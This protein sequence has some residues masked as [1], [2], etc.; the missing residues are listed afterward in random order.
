MHKHLPPTKEMGFKHY[1]MC[2]FRRY[3]IQRNVRFNRIFDV[4]RRC[5]GVSSKT[6]TEKTTDRKCM[7]HSRDIIPTSKKKKR[8][9]KKN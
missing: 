5:G 7:N 3:N 6:E 8:D 1:Q 4:D 9:G 2:T